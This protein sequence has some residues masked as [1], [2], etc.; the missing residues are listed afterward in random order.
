MSENQTVVDFVIDY[1]RSNPDFFVRHPDLFLHLSLLGQSPD[2]GRTPAECQN[3]A[4]KAALSSCRIREE[5][6][7]LREA[8]LNSEAKSEEIIRFATDLLACHS[9]VEIP[10]LV[11]SFFISEFKAAHGLLRLWPVK[12]NFSFFRSQNAWGRTWKL[13][14]V[15]SKIS[16]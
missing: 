10:N 7:K 13:P 12:P 4:L 5:E 8:T 15:Q 6:R 3:E 1:L 14:W 9:Q 16:I 2:G 11:L